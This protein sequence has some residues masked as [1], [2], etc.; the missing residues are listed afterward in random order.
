M[1][2][3]DRLTYLPFIMSWVLMV[4][5]LS[6]MVNT[7]IFLWPINTL[8]DVFINLNE[9]PDM[10]ISR[11]FTVFLTLRFGLFDQVIEWVEFTYQLVSALTYI[12][13]AA[14]ALAPI[15]YAISLFSGSARSKLALSHLAWWSEIVIG[16]SIL[17]LV[18]AIVAFQLWPYPSTV[19]LLIKV[20]F[21]V[22]IL[23]WLIRA[24]ERTVVPITKR[25]FG[26]PT[27]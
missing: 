14:I 2:W 27:L 16:L 23:Y 19:L 15:L 7:L 11:L 20:L 4:L 9:H 1:Q 26:K 10:L 24:L 25:Y 6:A 17:M 8:N 3:R 5:F 12:E 21:G 13:V 18:G 22:L